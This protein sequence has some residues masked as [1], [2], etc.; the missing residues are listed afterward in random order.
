MRAGRLRA[1]LRTPSG[2]AAS[3]L[4]AFLAF[5]VVAAP[6]IW[7]AGATNVDVVAAN[8]GPTMSHWLGTDSLGRDVL[9]RI[10][11]AT[12]SSLVL[13]V[14]ATAVGGALGVSLGV[15]SAVTGRLGGRL[16]GALINLLLAFPAL[17]LAIFFAVIFGLGSTASVF[18]VGA[19]FA[20]GFARLTQTLAA[21]IADRD[22]IKASR[23]LGRGRLFVVRR[24]ILPNVSEPLLLYG[25]IHVGTAILTLA[26]LSFLGLGVQPPAY[27]WGGLLSV[28]LSQ[29]YLTPAQAIG[30]AAAIVV[31]GVAC[32]LAGEVLAEALGGRRRPRRLTRAAL[33]LAAPKAALPQPAPRRDTVL[34]VERLAVELPSPSGT[35]RPVREVSF[36]LGAEERI[37]IVGESG[38]GKSITALAIARLL[39]PEATTHAERLRFCGE[40]LLDPSPGAKRLLGRHMALVFQDPGETLNPA[41]KIQTHLREPAE[42]HLGLAKRSALARAAASLRAVAIP[43]VARRLRQHQHELSGGMK[44]RVSIAVALTTEPR[45]L[46]AD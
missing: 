2:I 15:L 13:A 17:L 16:L 42:V 43:D 4:L 6:S 7:G 28:G 3:V 11:V 1:A 12:R 30:P 34:E 19:S 40:D 18:A 22:Y 10:L 29:I 8:H 31:A 27:D 23:M 41:L 45:L 20:P 35:V 9:D 39:G 46:I 24:H 44:Q 21:S 37:G 33:G 14:L 26:G 36:S 25:T 32:N 5:L 38:S